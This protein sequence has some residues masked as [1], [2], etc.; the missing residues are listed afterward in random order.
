MELFLIYDGDGSFVTE[1]L[2]S[3]GRGCWKRLILT[4][5]SRAVKSHSVVR[6]RKEVADMPHIG[7]Q[8]WGGILYLLNKIFLSQAERAGEKEPV[9]RTEWRI[10]AW[11]AYLTGLPAWTFIFVQ[12]RNWIAAALECSGVPS[13]LLGL[14]TDLRKLKQLKEDANQKEEEVT[15]ELGWLDLL[16]VV[17]IILGLGYS[18]YDFGGLNTINQGLEL[19]V[20]TG[21][22]LGTYLIAKDKISGYYWLMLMNLSNASLM[23]VQSYPWLVLQQ[24]ISLCFVA[25]A[26]R[27]RRKS[28]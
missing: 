18:L 23:Y 12:E 5:I 17:A 19:A 21:F 14:T 7:L 13:M 22:L 24:L 27:F 1:N 26:L 10:K 15:N 20:V 3:A 2:Y 25:D 8:L 11:I 16:S 6:R 28:S 4:Y 9:R